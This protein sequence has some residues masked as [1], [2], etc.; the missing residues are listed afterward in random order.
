MELQQKDSPR[1]VWLL[2]LLTG[3]FLLVLRIISLH[4]VF[5]PVVYGDEFI[6]WQ[7]ML[8][9]FFSDETLNSGYPPLY[10]FFMALGLLCPDTYRG[11][12][13]F[14]ALVGSI[15]PFTAW[16]IS[17]ELPA[18]IRLA[19]VI[20]L[21]VL[22]LLF[23][24]PRMMMS[25]NLFI[26]LIALTL[27]ALYKGVMGWSNPWFLLAGILLWLVCMTRYQGVPF[28]IAAVLAVTSAAVLDWWPGKSRQSGKFPL[29]RLCPPLLLL[30]GVPLAGILL[31]KWAGIPY[32]WEMGQTAAYIY[33]HQME[34][35]PGNLGM[36]IVF[37]LSYGILCILPLLPALLHGGWQI[38]RARD[39]SPG[40]IAVMAFTLLAAGGSLLVAA[41][42]SALVEYNHPDP[43][44]IM[45]RYLIFLPVM[46]IL[47]L[48]V[49][50]YLGE[51]FKRGNRL[52]YFCLW[53]V[54]GIL[55]VLAYGTIIRGWFF[56]IPSWFIMSQTALDVFAYKAHAGVLAAALVC[57][58][59]VLLPNRI[60]YLAALVMF[61]SFASYSSR[62]GCLNNADGPEA[63]VRIL[64]DTLEEY[65]RGLVGFSSGTWFKEGHARYYLRFR[66][67][68]LE[69]VRFGAGFGNS[70]VV[71]VVHAGLENESLNPPLYVSGSGMA[72]WVERR[73]EQ[74]SGMQ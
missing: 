34:L 5:G 23:V 74:S 41:R 15:L 13:L 53:L 48:L 73:E 46:S 64:E 60:P 54:C 35:S 16:R 39:R 63:F 69:R 57:G 58:L 36:W 72:V 65:P 45:G 4:D 29:R 71:A 1:L 44:H 62:S 38:L 52:V 31:W 67:V 24:Y 66:G 3:G 47:C 12:L 42:H 21:S 10:P 43:S 40:G 56:E 33:R 14:N 11:V 37:Y 18:V 61:F 6:Y 70:D 20:L 32:S 28:V 2:A 22:P 27:W 68:D 50:P 7:N 25:E 19:A 55:G 49:I 9:L 30:G 17:R 51:P 26:P 8:A 59:L